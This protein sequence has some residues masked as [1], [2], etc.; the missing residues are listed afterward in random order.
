MWIGGEAG[1]GWGGVGKKERTKPLARSSGMVAFGIRGWRRGRGDLGSV[2][3]PKVHLLRLSLGSLAS[4]DFAFLISR[5]YVR[6][7]AM[8]AL[9]VSDSEVQLRSGEE[10]PDSG[11]GEERFGSGEEQFDSGEEQF[12]SEEGGF[13]SREEWLGLGEEWLNR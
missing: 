4:V 13:G 12:D 5:K 9:R 2:W 10:Q 6:F 7:A 1:G 11:S 8:T 3:L